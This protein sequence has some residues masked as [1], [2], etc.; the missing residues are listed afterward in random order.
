L[1]WR[2]LPAVDAVLDLGRGGACW[3]GWAESIALPVIEAAALPSRYGS[4]VDV[5]RLAG[6]LTEALDAAGRGRE[7]PAVSR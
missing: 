1:P 3:R 4:V 2:V 5:R 7:D 6:R